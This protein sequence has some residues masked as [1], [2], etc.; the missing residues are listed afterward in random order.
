MNESTDSGLT[1]STNHNNLGNKTWNNTTS[2]PSFDD[3]IIN[4][5]GEEFKDDFDDVDPTPDDNDEVYDPDYV[6]PDKQYIDVLKEYFGH[7]KFRP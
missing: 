1:T 2:S 6:A 5:C 4:L 3:N 7:S